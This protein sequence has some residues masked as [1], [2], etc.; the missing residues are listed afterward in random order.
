MHR[1]GRIAAAAL[2]LLAGCGGATPAGNDGIEIYGSDVSPVWIT[3]SPVLTERKVEGAIR[4]F[5]DEGDPPE[6]TTVS[7]NGVPLP[8]ETPGDTRY[9]A[10]T[11]AGVPPVPPGGLLTFEA[12][13]GARSTR[14]SFRCPEAVT[15]SAAPDPIQRGAPVTISW[16][17]TIFPG[18]FPFA[19]EP[20]PWIR[21]CR[22]DSSP[23]GGFVACGSVSSGA[24]ANL[25]Y[26]ATS[27]TVT[28][29]ASLAGDLG[30]LVE[31]RF[32]APV[33]TQQFPGGQYHRGVCV[34][35][36]QT[37]FAAGG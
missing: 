26:P 34:L 6:E 31:L 33:A 17:G 20:Q 28:A 2:A 24:G 36:Q 5:V 11:G 19:V 18:P 3:W 1:N 10:I 25:S 29:P 35:V 37:A 23:P 9:Y 27:A 8:P 14:F 4:I 30:Y 15:L 21:L 7:L 32:P 12:R 16:S 22:H 13:V